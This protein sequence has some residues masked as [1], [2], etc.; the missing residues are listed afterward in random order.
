[1]LVWKTFLLKMNMLHAQ[2]NDWNLSLWSASVMIQGLS[3][4]DQ[5]V[6]LHWV[7]DPCFQ[8]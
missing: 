4:A 5:N 8:N 3:V 7:N 2:A 6:T 1:M